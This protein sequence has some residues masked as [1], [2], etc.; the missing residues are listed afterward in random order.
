MTPPDIIN[1]S[2]PRK[3]QPPAPCGHLA[4]FLTA[5]LLMILSGPLM[6]PVVEWMCR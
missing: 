3:P 5:V 1:V 6:A 4:P 2:W